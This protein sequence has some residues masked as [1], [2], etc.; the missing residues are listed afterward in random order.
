MCAYIQG[1]QLQETMNL[2]WLLSC[3]QLIKQKKK[4]LPCIQS[5]KKNKGVFIAKRSLHV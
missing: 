1:Y 2:D 4:S 3:S 5:N